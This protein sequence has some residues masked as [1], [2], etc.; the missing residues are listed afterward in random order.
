MAKNSCD[1]KI[2]YYSKGSTITLAAKLLKASKK[3]NTVYVSLSLPWTDISENLTA[4]G[5]DLSK[6]SFIDCI[7]AKYKSERLPKNVNLCPINSGLL[8]IAERISADLKKE[9]LIIFD[10]LSSIVLSDPAEFAAF[11]NRISP[12]LKKTGSEFVCLCRSDAKDA[13]TGLTQI[14]D[15]VIEE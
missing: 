3:P 13:A 10:S 14:F 4:K 5:A 2:L 12:A 1:Q 8:G 7:S 9:T 15:L 11:V 6:V